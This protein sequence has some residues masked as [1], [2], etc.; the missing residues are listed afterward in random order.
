MIETILLGVAIIAL[1]CMLIYLNKKNDK[2]DIAKTM[3]LL[4]VLFIIWCSSLLVQKIFIYSGLNINPIYFDYFAYI[5]ICYTFPTAYIISALYENKYKRISKRSLL[6]YVI[7]TICLLFLWTNDLHHLFYIKYSVNFNETIYGPVFNINSVYSYL[8]VA[9]FDIKLIR[10]S[11]KK[12]GF[13]SRQTFLIILGGMIPVIPNVLG[14]L[15][16]IDISIYVTPTLFTFTAVCYALAIFKYKALNITPIAFK[17]V[18]DTMSD[19]FIVISNDGTVVDY[20]KTF[21]NKFKEFFN[22][23]DEKTYDNLFDYL[24]KSKIISKNDLYEKIELTRKNGEIITEEYHIKVDEFDRYFEVD[25]HPI[26]A[27]NDAKDY[28][29]TLLLFKDITQHKLDMEELKMKQDII[30]K[31]GQLVS[32]GELAGGVAHDINTPISAIK[33]GILML[34]TMESSK[35][36][37]EKEILQRMDNCA[38]RIINIVNSMRNQIRNLGG[39]TNVKFKIADVVNDVKVITYHEIYKNKSTIDVE[40]QGDVTI[41]GDPTKLGQVLTNLVVNAA[42]AYNENG[43][44]IILR[45][46]KLNDDIAFID[47]I[48]FAG[49]I[50]ESIAPFVFKNILTT[51]GTNGTGLGL[52]LAYSVVKGEFNGEI[53]FSTKKGNGTTFHIR[54]PIAK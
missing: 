41:K 53:D 16:I 40:I 52:Y 44:K 2:S 7:P 18:I 39:T 17:T 1:T 32:I 9:I 29:G 20:N 14:V 19:A 35:T 33:T 4:F 28:I 11:I 51:K 49:G 23:Y 43:G 6:F 3:K 30:V 47:V 8:L 12:S 45:V 27:R 48:D 15:K 46:G 13:F 5:G 26:S 54:I 31:Q 50:D 22:K 34:N 25:I 38:T 37:E 21:E 42:Q 10:A 36:E 24:D